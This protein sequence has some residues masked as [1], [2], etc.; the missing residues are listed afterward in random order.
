MWE[1]HNNNGFAKSDKRN[2]AQYIVNTNKDIENIRN[3]L[4][5]TRK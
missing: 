1:I 2:A 5:C 4:R 3:N